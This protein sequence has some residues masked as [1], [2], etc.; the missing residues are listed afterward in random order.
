MEQRNYYAI[1]CTY[2][3]LLILNGDTFNLCPRLDSWEQYL[4]Q[5]GEALWGIVD[6]LL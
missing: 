6:H 5:R 3:A 4:Q 1:H 2:Q